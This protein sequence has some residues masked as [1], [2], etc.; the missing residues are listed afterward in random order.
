MTWRNFKNFQDS[1]PRDYHITGFGKGPSMCIFNR[2]PRC[3]KSGVQ[4]SCLG[5]YDWEKI[6][7]WVWW[8]LVV[9]GAYRKLER[10]HC[11]EQWLIEFGKV[12]KSHHTLN[13]VQGLLLKNSGTFLDNP[14]Q[15]TFHHHLC[16]THHLAAR[17]WSLCA[18]V[19][20]K[21]LVSTAH[22]LCN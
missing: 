14:G 18:L 19:M 20:S 9:K 8:E 22:C 13:Q 15:G 3:L 6:H 5:K 21:V 11:A 2:C 12:S 10:K 17:S 1:I 4:G 16:H 7:G